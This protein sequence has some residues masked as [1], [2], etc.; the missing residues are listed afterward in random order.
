MLALKVPKKMAN[1][2]REFLLK[3]EGINLDFKIKSD[4]IYVYIPLP[5]KFDRELLEDLDP[6]YQDKLEIVESEFETWHKPPRS[7]QEQLKEHVGSETLS[8]LKKSF[9]IIGEVV[10]LEIP[11]EHQD[12][13]YDIG[14]AALDFT[15]RRS[16]YRK[17]SEIGGVERT[18]KFE[19]LAGEDN[20]HTLHQEY[21][22]RLELDVKQVYFSPRLATERHRI[23]SQ[24]KDGETILDMFTGVGPFS[25]LIAKDKKVEIYG[26]DINPQAIHYLKKNIQLNK[27]QGKI[28]PIQGDV[29][30]VVK[31]KKLKVDRVIMNL[32][33]LAWNFLDTALEALKY[34]GL[35]HYYEFA[36]DYQQPI[37]RIKKAAQGREVKILS[38]KKVKSSKP[39]EWQMVVDAQ[40]L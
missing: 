34:G 11:E 9:D 4:E 13:K 12:N 26:V 29:K 35:L 1:D 36:S 10:I 39:G 37:Q 17:D 5:E 18:R 23:A 3:N 7:M 22:C 6:S 40:I 15:G 21:G 25:I 8:D 28:I 24:V 30:E 31:T 2:I 19:H 27:L 20:T 38:A 33:G 16:V 14:Q 32:P